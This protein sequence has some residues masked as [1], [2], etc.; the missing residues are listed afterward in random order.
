MQH[1]WLRSFHYT[2]KL[3]QI[4]AAADHLNV[5]K[6]SISYQIKQLED[7]FNIELFTR[8]GNR[9]ILNDAG[10]RLLDDTTIFFDLQETIRFKLRNYYVS[11]PPHIRVGSEHPPTTARILNDISRLDWITIKFALYG[12]SQDVLYEWFQQRR[13]DITVS[14]TPHNL[15]D[16]LDGETFHLCTDTAEFV[17]G[18]RYASCHDIDYTEPVDSLIETQTWILEERGASTRR[19]FDN[20]CNALGVWPNAIINVSSYADVVEAVKEDLGIG[21]LIQSGEQGKYLGQPRRPL[22]GITPD[23]PQEIR[24]LLVLEKFIHVQEHVMEMDEVRAFIDLCVD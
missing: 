8:Q 16:E 2:A 5:S 9:L 14:Y 17:A 4:S 6:S 22:L 11:T 3:G 20:V 19:V 15:V 13:I 21:V 7:Y 18:K 12:E 23:L 1:S 10:T 24:F